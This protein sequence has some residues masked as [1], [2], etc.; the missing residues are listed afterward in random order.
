M[1]YTLTNTEL[2]CLAL[3]WQ[4]GTIHRVA[5][6]TGISVSQILEMDRK[7]SLCADGTEGWMAVRTCSLAFLLTNI[8]PKRQGNL[9]FWTGAAAAVAFDFE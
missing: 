7:Q 2:L 8:Y 5:E 4:G 3:G 9:K 6:A 1:K